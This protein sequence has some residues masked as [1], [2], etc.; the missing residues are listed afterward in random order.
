MAKNWL[1]NA[2]NPKHKGFCTPMTKSTC[3]PRRKAFAMTMKKHHGFHENGGEVQYD[4]GGALSGGM[5]GMSAGSSFGPVGMAAGAIIGGIFGSV[6]TDRKKQAEEEARKQ[7]ELEMKAANARELSATKEMNLQG[8]QQVLSNMKL[9]NKTNLYMA[10]G[11]KM[12]RM[13]EG[14]KPKTPITKPIAVSDTSRIPLPD[15]KPGDTLI[16]IRDKL[17]TF[18][19][20]HDENLYNSIEDPNRDIAPIFTT[21]T[22]PTQGKSND[23]SKAFINNVNKKLGKDIGFYYD[24]EASTLRPVTSDNYK[25]KILSDQYDKEGQITSDVQSRPT[26]QGTLGIKA[27]G[28]TIKTPSKNTKHIDSNTTL[29]TNDQGGTSGT[30]E[31][32][33]NIPM[34]K[35]GKEIGTIEPGELITSSPQGGEV[36]LT[37]RYGPNG[38]NDV[39]FADR[40]LQ[41][42]EQEQNASPSKRQEIEKQK[43]ILPKQNAAIAEKLNLKGRMNRMGGKMKYDNG[44]GLIPV[45]Y[46]PIKTGYGKLDMRVPTSS[47]NNTSKPFNLF[48]NLNS[49][50]LQTG[51][52]LAATIG[53]GILT[54]QTLNSQMGDIT[55]MQ[56][57]SNLHQISPI[58]YSPGQTSIDVSDQI[59]ATERGYLDSTQG[60]NTSISDPGERTALR[61]SA[62]INRMANLSNIYSGKQRTEVG[63]MNQNID[64]LNRNR[65]MNTQMQNEESARKMGI[66]MQAISALSGI[67]SK[68]LENLQG[69]LGELGSIRKDTMTMDSLKQGYRGTI[70]DSFIG[71]KKFGGK[72]KSKSKFKSRIYA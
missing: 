42:N 20:I 23:Y 67:K 24:P 60:L 38:Q 57:L 6:G 71:Q 70:G 11:G 72:I 54:D 28:G 17:G 45:T 51:L 4:W 3:T 7:M 56:K 59:N 46:N 36:V 47:I 1:N 5:S 8:D 35:G 34:A 14:G 33:Y 44:G 41:L 62:N 50:N 31:T 30:H 21:L 19:N 63:L 49:A 10:K 40:Y 69:V 52:G 43:R 64:N 66:N 27:N 13:A 16:P 26:G 68:R 32:G 53:T 15:L 22:R 65:T 55:E 39:S 25:Y 61:T 37:K 12:N 18:K 9:S 58:K 29:I 48:G 2:V